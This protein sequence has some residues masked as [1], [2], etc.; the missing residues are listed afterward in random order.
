MS[1]AAA[2]LVAR[3]VAA[4]ALLGGWG[5]GDPGLWERW[6]AER[7]L[8][9]AQRLADRISIRPSNASA[10]DWTR[11]AE[12]FHAVAS[13]WPAERWLAPGTGARGREI[14][15]LSLHARI[16]AGH[17]EFASGR[18]EPAF[19]AWAEVERAAAAMPALAVEAATARAEAF[20]EL[21]RA[22]E[23]AEAWEDIVSTYPALDPESGSA[24]PGVL[25]AALE[26][27]R[28]WAAAGRPAGADSALAIGMHA[29][30][31]TLASAAGRARADIAQAL[32][33]VRDAAGDPR[34]AVEARRVALE[35]SRDPVR[36]AGLLLGGA[37]SWLAAGEADSARAW[38]ARA[39]DE[40]SHAGPVAMRL[41]AIA[42][43]A[44][45]P[46]REAL[47]AWS[48]LLR[49]HPKAQDAAA[50]ARYRRGLL[51]EASG[52][53][54]LARSEF[55][56]LTAT[57]PTHPLAMEAHLR[58]AGHLARQGEDGLARLE[59]RR[60]IE[61]MDFLIATQHDDEVQRRTRR[62]R[63]ELLVVAEGPRPGAEALVEVWTRWPGTAEGDAAGLRA[64]ELYAGPLRDPGRA[65]ELWS[66]L[67]EGAAAAADR[68]R[69]SAARARRGD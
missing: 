50:E 14:A 34:G 40:D 1:R 57:F 37:E 61:T 10:Q 46:P 59:A 52:P 19:A 5:C 56:V 7:A 2:P 49:A 25:R 9:R 17:V 8:W 15:A 16:S 53:W 24:L 20:A 35:A 30:D 41:E 29:L 48:R 67:A 31:G 66:A 65:R 27:G 55:G 22:A 21:G 28:A 23:A 12:A 47:E 4:L 60:A 51:L 54:A 64:A 11:A 42:W 43:E 13:R 69:A 36:R 58:I 39:P 45:G 44:S 26:A 68:A 18:P 6:Q 3:A 62:T 38:A 32:A 63:A 33:A